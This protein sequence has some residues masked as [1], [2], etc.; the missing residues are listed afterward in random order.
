MVD[1]N[2]PAFKVFKKAL[3]DVI[4]GNCPLCGD[5]IHPNMFKDELSKREY[6]ISGLC[7][8]C[9]DDMFREV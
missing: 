4:D 2:K 5:A 6:G 3:K 1:A 8:K 9:Q 7:Q